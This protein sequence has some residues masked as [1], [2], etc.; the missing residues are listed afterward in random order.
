MIFFL[1]LAFPRKAKHNKNTEHRF[2]D[3]IITISQLFPN[4]IVTAYRSEIVEL[5][6]LT[7]KPRNRSASWYPYG[8][9]IYGKKK[10]SDLNIC[11]L[12]SILICQKECLGLFLAI[13]KI[14]S[15][16]E[17]IDNT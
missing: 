16:L 5:V 1:S 10:K 8:D 17:D 6:H 4:V 7:Q 12:N 2:S 15:K 14:H 13:R 9:S 11:Y 3:N